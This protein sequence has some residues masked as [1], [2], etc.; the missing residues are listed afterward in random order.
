MRKALVTGASRG[1]GYAIAE[2]LRKDG[3]EVH[4]P[5]HSELDLSSCQ[6]I[7]AYCEEHKDI[8]YDVIINNAGINE[9]NLIENITEEEL[10]KTVEI[11][12]LG[13]IRLIRGLVENMKNQKYG[14][15][16]NIGSIWGIAGK[17]GRTVYAA[18]KHAIHGITQTLAVELA[19][20]NI[21]VNTVCPGFTMTELTIK[22]NTPEQIEEV[23][24]FIPMQRMAQPEEQAKV[25]AFLVGENNTYVTGQQIAVD[26]GYTAR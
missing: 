13:P 10:I 4:A 16:V 18:T 17:P 11:N 22:N 23:S 20:Y 21:L 15:I 14:K 26:G 5:T 8:T 9:I 24:S 6:S 3:F 19:P 25:V 1:I 2:Q 12:L 7:D